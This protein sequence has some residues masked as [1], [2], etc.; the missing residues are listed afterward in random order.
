MMPI[1]VLKEISAVWQT[2]DTSAGEFVDDFQAPRALMMTED[3]Y[4]SISEGE[5]A[6]E[7]EN[8]DSDLSEINDADGVIDV[9]SADEGAECSR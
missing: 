9:E 6:E 2:G 5:E 3:G 1:D 7:S 4:C 8:T